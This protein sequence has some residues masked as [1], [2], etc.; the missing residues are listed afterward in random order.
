MCK[1]ALTTKLKLIS[2]LI[3]L[4]RF[5]HIVKS[6]IKSDKGKPVCVGASGLDSS[7]GS[8]LRSDF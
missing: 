8:G 2:V 4:H 3:V 7:A 1:L 6:L 5:S